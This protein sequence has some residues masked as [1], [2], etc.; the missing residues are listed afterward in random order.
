MG[1]PLPA[2]D[3]STRPRR[4]RARPKLRQ[5]R[6][7]E[8]AA[9]RAGDRAAAPRPE[10]TALPAVASRPELDPLALARATVGNLPGLA[11]LPVDGAGLPDALL[12]SGDT[13]LLQRGAPLVDGELFAIRL[14][15]GS[16]PLL[17]RLHDEGDYLRLQPENRAFPARV[18]PRSEVLVEG[19]V[20]AVMRQRS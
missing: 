16:R 5:L 1:Q 12:A 3:Y 17:R 18:V 6:L 7:G 19:R 13:V 10:L 8:S 15:G 11:A 20:V 9:V 2:F 4:N 14:T